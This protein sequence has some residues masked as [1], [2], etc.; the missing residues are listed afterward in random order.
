MTFEELW[1]QVKGLPDAAKVLLPDSLSATTKK[2][3]TKMMPE[4][5]GRVV[6]GAID[7]V[8]NGSTEPLDTLIKKRLRY[9]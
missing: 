3:L 2:K 1:T 6:S 9:I 4:E 7:E 5:V 8:N